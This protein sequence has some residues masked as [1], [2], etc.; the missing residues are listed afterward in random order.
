LLCR[1]VLLVLL[2]VLT[3]KLMMKFVKKSMHEK[4][5]NALIEEL[6]SNPVK[7][8]K[9]GKP[10][11]LLQEY[12]KGYDTESLRPL[13]QSAN[14][15]IQSAAIFIVSELGQKA[16]SLIEDLLPLLNNSNSDIKYDALESVMVC[17]SVYNLEKFVYIL[18]LMDDKDDV[19]RIRTME[20]VCNANYQQ[21]QTAIEILSM[22]IDDTSK[23]HI[24]GLTLLLNHE[25][26]SREQILI[27]LNSHHSIPRK[28]GAILS[29]QA[30]GRFPGLIKT[31]VADDADIKQFSEGTIDET[32]L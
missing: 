15:Y 27:L 1:R 2:S 32:N 20:L 31:L 6:I 22:N 14:E 19:I 26:V 23:M 17:S 21:I 7:F 11:N 30:F 4:T 16:S 28:Y 29:R 3:R 5:G 8:S 24:N 18:P 10:Y 13:L 25:H 12:F 9:Q